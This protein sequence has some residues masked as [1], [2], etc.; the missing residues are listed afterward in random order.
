[1][2]AAEPDDV[3]AILGL[4]ALRRLIVDAAGTIVPHRDEEAARSAL[5]FRAEVT[6]PC[7]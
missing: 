7:G 5:R 6:A 4:G 3:V 1:M 2:L